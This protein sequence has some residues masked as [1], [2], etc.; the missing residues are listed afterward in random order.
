MTT[1]NQIYNKLAEIGYPKSFIRTRILPAWWEDEITESPGGVME[2][3]WLL[4]KRLEFTVS[5]LVDESKVEYLDQVMGCDLV[6][7]ADT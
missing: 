7:T 3:A 5:S 2:M 4:A 1:A 6:E